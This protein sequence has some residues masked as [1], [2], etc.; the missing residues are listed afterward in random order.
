V[1]EPLTPRPASPGSTKYVCH[2]FLT[3]LSPALDAH[4]VAAAAA[5]G[6]LVHRDERGAIDAFLGPLG[7][8]LAAIQTL[9]AMSRHRARVKRGGAGT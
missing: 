1:S 9:V 7:D 3:P 6:V 8:C 5:H 4:A 2:E